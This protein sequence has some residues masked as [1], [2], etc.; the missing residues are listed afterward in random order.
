MNT[1]NSLAA[2]E[3]RSGEQ[4]SAFFFEMESGLFGVGPTNV[5]ADCWTTPMTYLNRV[6]RNFSLH[7]KRK[8]IEEHGKL[9]GRVAQEE[10]RTQKCQNSNHLVG[11]DFFSQIWASRSK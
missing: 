7:F 6:T 1:Q 11:V 8:V 2:C 10:C 3:R 9:S 5:N 4:E